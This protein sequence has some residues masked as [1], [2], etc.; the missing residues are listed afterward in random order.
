MGLSLPRSEV[1]RPHRRHAGGRAPAAG[2][3]AA[4]RPDHHARIAAP[5]ADLAG[6][7][8][9][10]AASRTASSMRS[11]PCAPTSAASSWRCCW[12]G[13]AARST[14]AGFVASAC[15]RRSGRSTRSPAISAARV[16]ADGRPEPRPV[17]IVDAGAAQGPRPA[18]RQPRRAVRPA[19]GADRSG[20]RSTALLG[21]RSASHRSTIV[22]ANNRRSVERIT[23]TSTRNS[24]EAGAEHAGPNRRA[25]SRPL[26]CAHH[27]SVALEVRQETEEALKEGRLPA[28]VATASLELGID[29]GAVDLVCQVESP[30]NVARALQRVGRAGHLVGQQSKG[31]LIPKT[32]RDLLEQAV[33][34]ARD[35]GR[36]R[37]GDP[38]ADATA[39]TCWPSRSWPWWRWTLGRPALYRPGPAGATRTA[40]CRRQAFERCWK[41]SAAAIA[42]RGPAGERRAPRQPLAALQPRISWDRVHNRL[43]ALPGSQRLA[44]V[45]GGTIPDTGQYAVY[46]DDGVRIGELDEEFIYERRVGDTFLLGTNAWRIERIEADRVHRRAGRGGAGHGAVLARRERRPQLRPRPGA[47]GRFLRE[48]AEPARSPDCLDWLQS[49]LLPR[50]RRRPQRPRPRQPTARGTGGLPTDRTLVSRGVAR[51][52]RRLAG[53][54][55]EPARRPAAPGAAA[56]PRDTGCGSGS[57]IAR[58]ACTTTTAS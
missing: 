18:R 16:D 7:R 33:L 29:M 46:T 30:G 14:R 6:P 12:S 21:D 10:C 51:P 13:C 58:S 31:R 23:A 53:H 38:R 17:T 32:P 44:L 15:R 5:A 49:E 4:A 1:G 8:R 50:R 48:L 47:I 20:R 41:W 35:G 55:A 28:V 37:R 43:L 24:P 34:A 22:F 2:P 26:A 56:G 9:R 54:P 25:A 19:A 57:A 40:T 52:A 11:T 39:S 42:S 36:P 45:S 27:G 3:P